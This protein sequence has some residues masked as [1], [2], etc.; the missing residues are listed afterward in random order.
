MTFIDDI[1]KDYQTNLKRGIH[2]TFTQNDLW[3]G[4]KL[5]VTILGIAKLASIMGA[6]AFASVGAIFS[7]VVNNPQQAARLAQTI[8]RNKDAILK[9]MKE[10]E[11]KL[12]TKYDELSI[13]QKKAIRT[14][15][16]IVARN[17][18]QLSDLH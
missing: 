4:M 18:I 6:L 16:L 9:W 7:F 17:G 11:S 1:V 14:V 12:D 10:A 8:G 13:G 3:A 15:V 2:E 5:L